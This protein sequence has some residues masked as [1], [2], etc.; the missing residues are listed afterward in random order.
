MLEVDD[1]K[2]NIVFHMM[3]PLESLTPHLD[4]PLADHNV[5]LR[6]LAK[7]DLERCKEL[8]VN[9]GFTLKNLEANCKYISPCSKITKKLFHIIRYLQILA[10]MQRL[11][12][13]VVYWILITEM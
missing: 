8:H 12:Y 2:V 3:A 10:G 6:K 7:E 13:V 11:E 4:S 9:E 5:L 1:P